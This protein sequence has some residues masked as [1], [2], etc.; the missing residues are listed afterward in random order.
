MEGRL[1]RAV[2]VFGIAM[3][4]TNSERESLA[5]VRG[6]WEA[7]L[8]SEETIGLA[9][10]CKQFEDMHPLTLKEGVQALLAAAETAN[11]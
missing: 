5:R 8:L 4:E 6:L 3:T 9:S 1:D 10:T 11:A 7:E 2:R